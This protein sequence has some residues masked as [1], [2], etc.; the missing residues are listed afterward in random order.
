ML[1]I[2]GFK[3]NLRIIILHKS[4]FMIKPEKPK[5]VLKYKNKHERDENITFFEEGHKYVIKTDP[6][7]KYLSVTSW[8]H[9]HFAPFNDEEIITKMMKGKNWKP[10]HKYWGL[11]KE[12]IKQLWKANG[13][14]VSGLGTELHFDIECFMNDDLVDEDNNSIPYTQEDLLE[15]YKD[16]ISNGKEHYNKSVEWKYFINFITDHS[17]LKPYRTEWY[18]YH[19]ELKLAGSIDMVYELPCGAKAIY[20]WK[21]SKEISKYSFWDKFAITSCIKH[22]PDLNF[23]HYSLQLNTYKAILEEKYG[24]EIKELYLVKLHPDNK[25]NNYE[26]IKCADLSEEVKLLFEYRLELLNGG[27][28]DAHKEEDH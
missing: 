10:G 25:S 1:V 20:D 11:T 19:E 12:D 3:Y 15:V 8:N 21:R 17:Q 27:G 9:I 2:Q 16:D 7:T 4:I 14:K 22:I 28:A 6:D 24:L 18:I 23:W 5:E 13:A 26:L